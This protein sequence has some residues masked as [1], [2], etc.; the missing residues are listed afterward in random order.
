VLLPRRRLLELATVYFRQYLELEGSL[1]RA[2]RYIIR[3]M[4]R[5]NRLD[6]S[7]HVTLPD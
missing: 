6:Y 7:S 4:W 2:A 3:Q 1:A 5:A